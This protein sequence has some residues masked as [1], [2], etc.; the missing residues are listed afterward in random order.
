M[1]PKKLLQDGDVL[2]V[3]TV[4]IKQTDSTT[5]LDVKNALR[6]EDFWATQDVVSVVMD[7][8]AEQGE[9]VHDFGAPFRIYTLPEPAKKP[10]LKDRLLGWLH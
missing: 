5:T 9:L 2:R 6:D 10:S 1:T 8:L 4:L 3:A 7:D